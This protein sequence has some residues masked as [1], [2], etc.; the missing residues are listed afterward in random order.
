MKSIYFSILLALALAGLLTVNTPAAPPEPEPTPTP[1]VINPR[2]NKPVMPANPSR[3]DLGA[4]VYWQYCLACHGD[5]GQGLTDEFRQMAFGEDMNCWQSKCHASNHPQPGFI[6]P[7]VVPPVI[8]AGTL[9]RFVTAEDLY[10]YLKAKMP[11][12]KYDMLLILPDD[13]YW[14]VTAYLLS[15]NGVLPGN[16]DFDP[17]EALIIPVH[18]P[19]RS[20]GEEQVVQSVL[21][22]SLALVTIGFLVSNRWKG[23]LGQVSRPNFIY[24]MHPPSIPLPQARWRYTLGAGG[25]AVF[26]L[27][28]IILTGILEMFFYVPTLEM[29]GSSIQT[30]TFSVPYG[31]L[32]RGLHFWAAQALVV[33]AA[34]HLLRVI[35]TGAYV[36][37]RRFNYLLGL[38]LFFLVLLLDFTGYVLRWDEGIRW[39]LTVGTNLLKTIPLIGMQLYAF[40]VGGDQPGLT[41]L[42][43]FYA[44]HIFGLAAI[45][46]AIFIWHIFRVRRDGGI[47]APPPEAR[48]DT[49]RITRFELVRRE[50]LA[51]LL[52]VI[53]LLVIAALLPAPISTPIQEIGGAQ[54]AEVRAPW[55]FL[56]VQQMLRHG[57]AFWLGV[58]APLGF[59]AVLV[60]LP[61]LFP[62]LP[63]D[64]RGRWF[65]RAGRAAQAI[66]I[67]LALAWLVLTLLE[68]NQ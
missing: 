23:N 7:R 1:M 68:L 55:F 50:V 54:L 61:Y 2:M 42:T 24:H 60:A 59:L 27:L 56:W 12:Y 21:I 57:D 47:S 43:R 13:D 17:R 41:T 22:G 3:V 46:L 37:P 26:L 31:G 67:L 18:L 28:V 51:V 19:I 20:H 62:R 25:L 11:Y 8:G 16:V 49:R 10:L 63:G 53:V 30:I 65:P 6:F 44:W 9:K 36:Q 48:R 35:F 52:A 58:A 39:A 34:V 29:A 5:R 66:A 14:N 15:K 32:V 45:L 4:L 64:Q 33:V 38:G 40:V